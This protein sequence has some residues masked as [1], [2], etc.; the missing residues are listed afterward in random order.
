[1]KMKMV[2]IS[3]AKCRLDDSGSIHPEGAFA[4]FIFRQQ[5]S[6]YPNCNDVTRRGPPK[7]VA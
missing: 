6:F 3:L 1:M 2:E 5:A 7:E 4:S